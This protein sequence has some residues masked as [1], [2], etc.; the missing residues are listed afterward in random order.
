MTARQQAGMALSAVEGARD[1]ILER[2]E[3]GDLKPGDR[4]PS[5][6]ELAEALKVSRTTLRDALS[7]LAR[8]GYVTR[9]PGRGG[10]TFV[11]RPKVD[12][13]L[14]SLKGLPDHLHRQGHAASARL[15]S[16]RMM[17]SDSWTATELALQDG[18]PVFEIIRLRFSDGDP[19]SIE[20]SRFPAARFDGLLERG[21]GGSIYAIL[22]DEYGVPPTRARERMEPIAAGEREAEYLGVSAGA[23]LLS[24]DRVTF[25]AAGV[26]IEVGHD[27]FR[28]DRI[29]VVVSLETPGAALEIRDEGPH[30]SR[31]GR[32]LMSGLTAS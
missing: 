23:P 8:T 1:A 16:A 25:D 18:D 6:R 29:R 32:T 20:R 9:R 11:N 13:D 17:A 7:Q 30:A 27:L 24:V 19:I 4:L 21:L 2:M 15:L 10:G 5:E 28:G 22:R 12:R 31:E 26:P 14:T 3:S